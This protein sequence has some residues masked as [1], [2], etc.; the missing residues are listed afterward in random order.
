[1]TRS[2]MTSYAALF[3][4]QEAGAPVVESI[5]I[6]LIQRDYAQGREGDAVGRIRR[7][8]LDVLHGA[9][10]G[11]EPIS[12]DFVYGDVT[13]GVLEP[14]DGQQRLTTLFLLH[15]YLAH[16]AGVLAGPHPWTRFTYV[17]RASARLFCERLVAHP[18]PPDIPHGSAWIMDQPWYLDTWAHDPTIQS[19]LVM[20]DGIHARFGRDDAAS[21]WQRLTDTEAPALSFH[22]LPIAELQLSDQ[23]YIKMNSR[24]KPLTQFETFKA[25]FEQTLD[26]SCADRVEEFA[27]KVD[28]AWSDLLWPYR[29]DDDIIDDEFLR[30]F[31]FAT[32]LCAW[33]EDRPASSDVAGLAE[34]IY[35]RANERAQSHL[36]FLIR[37]FDTW[38]GVDIAAWF[39]EHFALEA[40]PLSSGE[41]AR[42]VITGLR[43]HPNADLF[44]AACRTYGISRGR[45]RL[46]PL[47]LTLYLFAVLLHRRGSTGDFLRRL[48]VVRNLV[49][50]SSN[51]LR[52]ERMPELLREVERIVV[53][54]DLDEIRTFN[55]AQVSEE[56]LKRSLLAEHPGLETPLFQLEDHSLLKGS[57]AAF[58]LE[59]ERF[60]DRAAAF[61]RIFA[62]PTHYLAVT[63]ALLAIGDYSRQLNHRFFQLGSSSKSA[64]WRELLAG[65]SRDKMD[66]TRAVLANLLDRISASTQPVVEELDVISSRWLAEREA[67]GAYSWRTYFV[68]YPAMREGDSGRYTGWE[69][70]LGYLLCMLRGERV[71]GNYRDPYL[72]AIHRLSEVGEAATDPWFTGYE[73]NP[74]WLNLKRSGTAVRCVEGGLALR[75]PLVDGELDAFARVCEDHGVTAEHVLPVPQV[76]IDGLQVDA[77]DRVQLGAALIR[78]LVEAGL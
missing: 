28:R 55:Q 39:D 38:E 19:M 52:I 6:P 65:V 14:L 21:A 78:D 41:T 51:E 44:D 5:R 42:V 74:R 2:Y 4:R 72:L 31:H 49:E 23:L 75:P 9:V 11:G 32:E 17:T 29:G 37:A 48:R 77:G 34:A 59:P 24:G 64:P 61:H 67:H 25:R 1:M 54:G 43:G 36:D 71:S 15:V 13:D 3:G 16:R 8:F 10:V 7:A 45:G 47:P 20:L 62:D 22:L 66:G 12:L 46:F 70:K 69:G 60:A 26:D 68:K 33:T 40:P 18:P 76:E 53:D 27:L 57:L 30:Y 63:G 73:S 50:A 56:R 58:E 35:G